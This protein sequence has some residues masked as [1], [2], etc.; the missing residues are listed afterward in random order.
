VFDAAKR[1]IVYDRELPAGFGL[2]TGEQGPRIFVRDPEGTT[3]IL[4]VKGIAR[5]DVAPYALTMLADSPVPIDA[6]GD[7]LG[8]R[9][10]FSS[11]SHLCSYK[12]AV[13]SKSSTQ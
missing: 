4:F 5:V 6:G 9:I 7:F 8:G 1:T 10:Y 2:T 13:K 12:V 11:G 3:Y